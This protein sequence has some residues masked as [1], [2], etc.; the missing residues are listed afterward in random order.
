VYR[1]SSLLGYP[2]HY[3]GVGDLPIIVSHSFTSLMLFVHLHTVESN[4][5]LS[6][7]I[8]GRVFEDQLSIVGPGVVTIT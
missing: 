3:H 6:C 8:Y 5:C 4:W 2:R 7:R 1:D